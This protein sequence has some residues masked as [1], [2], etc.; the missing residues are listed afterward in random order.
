MHA[1]RDGMSKPGTKMEKRLALEVLP[2]KRND[3]M[4]DKSANSEKSF[5]KSQK[6]WR[7]AECSCQ[8]IGGHLARPDSTERNNFYSYMVIFKFTQMVIS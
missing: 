7:G 3:F 5:L 8:Q 1:L 2:R 6:T 4:F